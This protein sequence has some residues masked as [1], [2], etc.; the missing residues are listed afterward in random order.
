M[1]FL[2]LFPGLAVL[3]IH[4]VICCDRVWGS[5]VENFPSP[6]RFLL[7]ILGAFQPCA[8]VESASNPFSDTARIHASTSAPDNLQM[9]NGVGL[10]ARGNGV[11]A[12]TTSLGLPYKLAEH[13]KGWAIWFFCFCFDGCILP[14]VLFYSLWY[15]SHL[16][17]WTSKCSCLLS[18]SRWMRGFHMANLRREARIESKPSTVFAIITSLSFWTAYHKWYVLVSRR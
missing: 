18:P 17:H 12:T 7:F 3:G 4:L 2:L 13:R 1:A 14:L 8:R 5:D 11:T 9:D 15:G 6:L 16:S 10:A